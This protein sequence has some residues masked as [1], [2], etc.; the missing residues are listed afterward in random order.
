MGK[1]RTITL[2]F[3]IIYILMV[4]TSASYAVYRYY[5]L[6]QHRDLGFFLEFPAKLLDLNLANQYNSGAAGVNMFGLNG[7]EGEYGFHKTLHFSPFKYTYLLVY[8]L[9]PSPIALFAYYSILYFLPILYFPLIHP[10]KDK[11]DLL[12]VT[13]V[14]IIFITLPNMLLMSTAE[15]RP[16]FLL[17]AFIPLTFLAIH[18]KRPLLERVLF[19]TLLLMVREEG[20][21]FGLV[22]ILYSYVHL[23]PVEGR[24][25]TLWWFS[26]IYIG[27]LLSA[28]WYFG[29]YSN[30]TY[31]PG[32][33]VFKIL[34]MRPNLL[35]GAVVL[36]AIYAGMLVGMWIYSKPWDKHTNGGEK[37]ESRRRI[38]L[39]LKILV[40]VL[41]FTPIL[42]TCL[43]DVL[44]KNLDVKTL[45]IILET[46]R[47]LFTEGR[48]LLVYIFLLLLIVVLWGALA[49]KNSKRNLLILLAIGPIFSSLFF[50]QS[51]P[52]LDD[53]FHPDPDKQPI[54]VLLAL[55]EETDRYETSILVGYETFIAFYD[56]NN[57]Y[58][59][60][61]LPV[62]YASGRSGNYPHN[63][64]L[65]KRLIE[66]E[67]DYLA[68]TKWDLIRLEEIIQ[69]SQVEIELI[70]ENQ[71]VLV[72]AV[73]K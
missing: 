14:V 8:K 2:I 52:N 3:I 4:F 6:L 46:G 70:S 17:N 29:V 32:D 42:I 27:N 57:I 59:Y 39:L 44:K 53:Y 37:I 10:R 26:I 15:I 68:I 65:I 22:I 18:Y 24:K 61:L 41:L 23:S 5:G 19:F 43:T 21:I 69:F 47:R 36:G 60:W 35:L 28:G 55:R 7:I 20:I 31:N 33:S 9:F 34:S 58:N 13:L 64:K 72:Y 12:F 45:S 62:E 30:L 71:F 1:N 67:I 25:K 56:Y 16:R 54:N 11:H 51:H 66:N 38:S 73:E 48:Y 49:R 63:A 40:Y 50:F